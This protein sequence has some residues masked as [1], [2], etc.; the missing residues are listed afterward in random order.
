MCVGI[1][2]CNVFDDSFMSDPE[3]A[4]GNVH[5]VWDNYPFYMMYVM[6]VFEREVCI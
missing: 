2:T 3:K 1:E 5:L 6:C 4:S